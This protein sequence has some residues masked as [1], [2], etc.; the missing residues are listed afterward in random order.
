MTLGCTYTPCTRRPPAPPKVQPE[1]GGGRSD[2]LRAQL[3]SAWSTDGPTE[4]GVVC[5]VLRMS[6][7]CKARVPYRRGGGQAAQD[8]QHLA[9]VA[10]S[11]REFSA[12]RKRKRFVS[13]ETRGLI[14]PRLPNVCFSPSMRVGLGRGG[15]SAT[16]TQNAPTHAPVCP[17]TAPLDLVALLPTCSTRARATHPPAPLSPLS[18]HGAAPSTI[19]WDSAAPSG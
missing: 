3:R 8:H 6:T 19:P 1:D 14:V 11:P 7:H 17:Q 5:C 10:R 15:L 16:R 4:R 9:T 2:L 18:G 13:L 12:D